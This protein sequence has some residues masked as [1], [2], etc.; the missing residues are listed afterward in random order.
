MSE[1]QNNDKNLKDENQKLEK[2]KIKIKKDINKVK[3]GIKIFLIL[4]PVIVIYFVINALT[5]LVHKEEGTWNENEKGRPSTYT[6][7][8]Q[9]SGTEGIN[10]NKDDLIHQA[11]LDMTYTEEEIANL[12][13]QEIIEILKVY[14]KLDKTIT[15][16]DELTHAEILW[17]TND[18]YS[19]Y[20]KTPEDLQRL[21]DAE[22]ITQYPKIDGLPAEK[23]NGIVEFIRYS[24]DPD[25]QVETV[26]TLKW[27][28]EEEFAKKMAQYE[29]NGNTDVLNYF[30]LD[31]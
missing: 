9:V 17:C 22:I 15:S 7:T 18:I 4:L 16:L 2:S 11:L 12:T 27:I 30:T 23:L 29:E 8:A 24:T 31:G 20:L 28:S 3:I 13:E 21:L 1:L 26:T 10:V 14:D 5:W 25:T 6:K 19:K